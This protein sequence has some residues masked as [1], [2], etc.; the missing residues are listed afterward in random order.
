[1]YVDTSPLS[2]GGKTSTRPLLR[3][4]YRAH[5]TG[6]HRTL[7][8]LSPCAAAAIAARRLALRHQQALENLGTVQDAVPLQQGGSCGAVWTLYHV[9]RRL[10]IAQA[11]GTTREGPLAVWP[12]IARGIAHGSRLS[13]VRLA[14][15]PAAWAG[16]GFGPWDEEAR[17]AH[18][19]GL[20]G[21]HAR[22]EDRLLAQRQTTK[23]ASLF[24]S[25]VTRRSLAGTHNA[26][27][28]FGAN[29]AGTTGKL[30]RVLGLLCDEAGPP[31]S[32]AVLPGHTPEPHTM[33]APVAQL[34]GRFGV[35][36]IPCVGD[37]G[38][39]QSQ[40]SEA[41]APQGCHAMPAMTTP[42]RETRRRTGTLPMERCAQEV[43]AG[44]ADEGV[45]YGLRRNPGRAQDVRDNRPAKRATL[46]ALVAKPNHS[47]KEP[48]RAHA[49]GA[50]QQL[51][52]RANT[53][54]LSDWGALT[55]EERSITLT[56]HASVQPE[57]AKLDGC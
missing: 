21:G 9:A 56:V 12:V 34:K 14:R 10:G 3:E 16:L 43:A 6:L 50:V 23:P 33:A 42:Q 29:R 57:A 27:A 47:L 32:L 8:P 38:M 46:Q 28:A 37:R 11:L 7:A 35:H 1:M 25:E 45:R 17:S 30:P 4:S 52:A 36:A 26:L 40:P 15:A 44:L 49:Q 24:L 41:L 48:R 22:R 13:T 20:A 2:R 39:R 55:G 51:V 54:R 18:L 31:V 5:G 19:D 53:R